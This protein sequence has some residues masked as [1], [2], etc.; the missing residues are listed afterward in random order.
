MDAALKA[1][2]D[3]KPLDQHILIAA[4]AT[5][6][7]T[8]PD[9]RAAERQVA[10]SISA[11]DVATAEM[12]PDISLTALFGLQ[13]ATPFS[14]TPW[15]LGG[16]LVQPILNFGRIQSQID[17]ADAQEKQAF[18]NY[19]QTVLEALENMENALSGYVHETSRNVSL[20][21]AVT[22]TRKASELAKQQYSNGYTSLLDVLVEERNLLDAEASQAAS[23][24]N[25]RKDLVNIYTAA[26][27]GWAD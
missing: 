7:A 6:L 13:T 19:Q 24:A 25:L 22:Q 5:V 23:D 12:F 14:S 21:A 2:Q 27:G 4:P 16:T 26:G 17:A 18:L 8:R 15:S 10:A 9:V 1:T 3:M 11:E 20:T